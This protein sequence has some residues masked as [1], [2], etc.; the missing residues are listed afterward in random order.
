M[1]KKADSSLEEVAVLMGWLW[2]VVKP[3]VP[4]F[5][6]APTPRFS[7]S[8]ATGWSVVRRGR[9]WASTGGLGGLAWT[10]GSVAE[11]KT[12]KRSDNYRRHGQHA[13]P[14]IMMSH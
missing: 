8:N 7:S 6:I 3:F 10:A 14:C 11:K 9:K 1:V 2:P 4:V 13:S 12:P 5:P